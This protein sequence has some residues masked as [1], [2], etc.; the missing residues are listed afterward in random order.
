[1][2]EFGRTLRTAR[3]AKGLSVGQLAEMTRLAPSVVEHLE[4]ENFSE[5]AAPIYGRGFVKLYC[6][7]VGLD[8]K[9]YIAEYMDIVNGAR[10][11]VIRER[12]VEADP[13]APEAKIAPAPE[14]A[15]EPEPA[16]LPEPAPA[17]EPPKQEVADDL[18]SFDATRAQSPEPAPEPSMADEPGRFSRYAAPIRHT[19][20][21]PSRVVTLFTVYRRLILLAVAALA[22]LALVVWGLSALYRVLSTTPAANEPSEPAK[23]AAAAPTPTPASKESAP[24]AE[25]TAPR[26]PQK[27]PD[28]YID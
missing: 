1:M 13:P 24:S 14:P 9:P 25:P 20:A 2:I 5:I 12:A 23:P 18:F 16:P 28:L 27:I 8:P 6:E 26:T 10:E 21:A 11:P 4:S 15:P 17:P 19:E 3:E 22:V 7:A